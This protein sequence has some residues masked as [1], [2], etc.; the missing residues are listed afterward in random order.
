MSGARV[1][2]GVC[3][4]AAFFCNWVRAL[5]SFACFLFWRPWLCRMCGSSG[6]TLRGAPGLPRGFN[7]ASGGC[8]EQFLKP[9][10]A[11]GQINY[12][13]RHCRSG[14]RFARGPGGGGARKEKL[15]ALCVIVL[16]GFAPRGFP[17][18]GAYGRIFI[19]SSIV[20]FAVSVVLMK[21]GSGVIRDLLAC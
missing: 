9:G 3:L 2:P 15:N 12:I 20:M 1:W 4:L 6:A 11:E 16:R 18:A 8:R 19:V 17:G 13:V 7:R 10:R 14:R 21:G 5:G